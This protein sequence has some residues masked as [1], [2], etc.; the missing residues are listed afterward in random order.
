MYINISL[1]S[2]LLA[3]L[4]LLLNDVIHIAASPIQPNSLSDKKSDILA[5][6]QHDAQTAVL[7]EADPTPPEV[8][9]DNQQHPP[10]SEP[11]VEIINLPTPPPAKLSL[12]NILAHSTMSVDVADNA[13]DTKHISSKTNINVP[14]AIPAN[15]IGLEQNQVEPAASSSE[16]ETAAHYVRLIPR[17]YTKVRIVPPPA[18]HIHHPPPPFFHPAPPHYFGNYM[19][20]VFIRVP[21]GY[22]W[23]PRKIN[24]RLYEMDPNLNPNFINRMLP[25]E[26]TKNEIT[27]N[28]NDNL[29]KMTGQPGSWQWPDGIP[30]GPLQGVN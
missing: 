29:E 15:M 26:E 8:I 10:E 19:P 24:S 5:A 2:I 3:S 20:R 22:Y 27:I 30:S 21:R 6:L 12:D 11:V 28:Q 16:P 7:T 13:A 17:V 23:N 4:V 9:P 14:V 1:P 25:K 18:P